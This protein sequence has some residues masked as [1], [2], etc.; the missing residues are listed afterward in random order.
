MKR[1]SDKYM[2]KQRETLSNMQ[3]V[4]FR[5]DLRFSFLVFDKE[6]KTKT[7]E[8]PPQQKTKTKKIS[9]V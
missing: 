7:K 8:P 6:N 3:N 1:G 4:I 9:R 5:G 2:Q